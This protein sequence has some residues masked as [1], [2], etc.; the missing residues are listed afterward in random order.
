MF[1]SRLADRVG[2]ILSLVSG[3]LCAQPAVAAQDH[4]QFQYDETRRAAFAGATVRLE[5]GPAARP[6]ATRLQLGLRSLS[7]GRQSEAGPKFTHVPLF[8]LG[9]A[10]RD[11]GNLF[12]A[13]Q[14][15][16]TVEKRLGLNGDAWTTASVVLT[17]ALLAVGVLVITS[18]DGL[19]SGGED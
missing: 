19:D 18:L 16:T 7:S 4:R 10:G 5:M 1:R 9:V 2:V 15:T 12:I 6:P 14:S 8:E 11:S 13:G 17:V 3:A